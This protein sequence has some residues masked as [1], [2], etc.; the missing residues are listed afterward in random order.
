MLAAQSG[1]SDHV[2]G[3]RRLS[4]KTLPRWFAFKYSIIR[5]LPRLTVFMS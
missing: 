5:D 2:L 3:T 1:A 4:L